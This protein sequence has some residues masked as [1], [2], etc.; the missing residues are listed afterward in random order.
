MV[1]TRGPSKGL[2]P[3]IRIDIDFT[4]DPTNPTRVWTCVTEDVRTLSYV[5]DGRNHELQR[6]EPGT[7]NAL[8]NNRHGDYD[9]TN[10][11]SPHYP[12]VKRMRWIRV[13]ARWGVTDY[14]RWT[15]LIETWRQEWPSSGKDATVRITAVSAL[16]VLNL[17]DLDGKSYGSQLTSARVGAVLADAGVAV[18][19]IDTGKSTVV[20]SGVFSRGSS[21]LEHLLQV[22]ETEN[23]LLF[24]NGD[25]SIDFQNRHY[26]L[27]NSGTPVATIGDVAGE[28]RYRD[29]TLD[30]DD[31]DIWNSVSVTPSGGIAVEVGDA[32]SQLA[33]YTRRLNRSSLSSDTAEAQSAAEYLRNRYGDPSPRVP[34]VVLIGALDPSTWPT[35]LAAKNSQRYTWK[36]RAGAHT[37]TQ[38]VFVERIADSI[39]LTPHLAW[40]ISLQL[41]PADGQAGWVLG[42][43]VYGIL[44]STTVLTY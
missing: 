9:P 16:K 30:L 35:I 27:L 6:T 15:G 12:G 5:L 44:G 17:Y 8:L 1:R 13:R 24:A 18:G 19:T 25:G 36:R 20:A 21:A 26:R 22:E 39:T 32:V 7:L 33:H 41:S 43:S 11:T 10:H 37:I 38:D 4:N 42:D 31:A 28:I 40:E 3:H 14:V 34:E 29:G 2:L 23:G